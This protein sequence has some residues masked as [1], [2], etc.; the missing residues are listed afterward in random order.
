MYEKLGKIPQ[1]KKLRKEA[2]NPRPSLKFGQTGQ[3][4]LSMT[5]HAELPPLWNS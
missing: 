3:A 1:R 4:T 5:H 2:E